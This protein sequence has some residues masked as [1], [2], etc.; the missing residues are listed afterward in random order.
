MLSH[1]TEAVHSSDLRERERGTHTR[2][3]VA[4]YVP[5]Y[6][7]L[8]TLREAVESLR[9]QC[10]PMASILT[11]DDGSSDGGKL[12]DSKVRTIRH[13]TN[14]GRGTAR[15]RAMQELD[16]EFIVCCDATNTLAPDFVQRLM[17]WF[18]DPKVAAVY[19]LIQ[20]K[21]PQGSVSRWRAR[22]LFKSG[23]PREVLHGAPLIT[24]G[25][26]VRRSAVMAV[27]NYDPKL[28]HSEDA[29]L[30]D[31]LLAAGYDIVA[32]PSVPVYCNV[33]NSLGQVLERYWRWYAGAG[34]AFSFR[35]FWQSCWHAVR[36]MVPS[37]LRSGEP[38]AAMISLCVPWYQLWR[39]VRK[40]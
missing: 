16:V 24:Y 40:K 36:V 13:E 19:G 35:T 33:S 10:V 8:E 26:I 21:C 4:G 18:D 11:I 20:D 37:D 27:G 1:M 15:S 2:L 31:R 7:N 3:Q 14:L 38:G 22:H 39:A 9:N 23:H 12:I 25:T 30:G 32:D 29:E 34:E 28:R 17:P 6:N 5:Y